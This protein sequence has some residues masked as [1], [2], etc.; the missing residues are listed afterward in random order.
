MKT[1]TYDPCFLITDTDE[2]FG[3]VGM[4][5]DDTLLLAD[6]K[7]AQLEELQLKE[8][9]LM[10]KEKESLSVDT[11]IVF[12]GCI[13]KLLPNGSIQ[14]CQK[15]QGKKIQLIDFNTPNYKSDYREQRARGAYI[16]SI[17]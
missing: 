12:N 2:S 3:I 14:I 10:A 13:M 16:G 7:F 15:E 4:Q 6:E 5:V 9:K 8:A 1:S 17:C 11:P